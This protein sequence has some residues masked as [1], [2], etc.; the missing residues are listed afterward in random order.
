MKCLKCQF[1]N[2]S[3]SKFRKECGT[4]LLAAEEISIS[5]TKTLETPTEELLRGT[6]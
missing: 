5:H 1:D 6:T 2:P 3:D 4:Q